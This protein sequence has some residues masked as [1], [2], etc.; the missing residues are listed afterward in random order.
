M[1]VRIIGLQ[2]E[3]Y[4]R[5]CLE[6]NNCDFTMKQKAAK[7]YYIYCENNKEKLRITLDENQETEC[8]SGWCPAKYGILK[9]ETVSQYPYFDKV[10]V[11][12]ISF[13]I[14][15]KSKYG[16][17]KKLSCEAFEYNRNGGDN[18]YPSGYVRVFLENFVD[19]SL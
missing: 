12:E 4:M 1:S 19:T 2:I 14:P 13:D 18:Y 7:R 5:N 9:I 3:D 10:P 15:E 16:Y 8:Y 17:Y 11:K 6:G